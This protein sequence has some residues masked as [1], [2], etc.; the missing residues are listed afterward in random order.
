MKTRDFLK[1]VGSSL[2][3]PMW[4]TDSKF[5]AT[6]YMAIR[7]N[8]GEAVFEAVNRAKQVSNSNSCLVLF[9]F[10]Y[11]DHFIVYPNGKW[12]C[13]REGGGMPVCGPN[14][15]FVPKEGWSSFYGH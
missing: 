6:E 4:M 5:D 3:F 11:C 1:V 12:I 15:E 2:L 7:V 14:S 10:N 13:R 9:T 8:S